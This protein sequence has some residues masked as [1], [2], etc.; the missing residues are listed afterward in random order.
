MFILLILTIACSVNVNQA[1]CQTVIT[2]N[3]TNQASFNNLNNELIRQINNTDN[4]TPYVIEVKFQSGNIFKFNDNNKIKLQGLNKQNINLKFTTTTGNQD[5]HI[6][7][8]GNEYSGPGN[9]PRNREGTHY[10]V[11]LKSTYTNSETYVDQNFN[12]VPIIDS[13][14]L[15]EVGMNAAIEKEI[16]SIDSVKRIAKI[17]I[18]NE[19][20]NYL[21]GR[22]ETALKNNLL[23]LKSWFRTHYCKIEKI[24]NNELFFYHESIP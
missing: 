17:V 18:S 21:P 16:Q 2:I 23:Y 7:S 3:V 11:E 1:F 24:V 14:N 13:G 9:Y 12:M 5:V 20:L 19:L 10:A 8:D 22:D 6:I 15:S 4:S